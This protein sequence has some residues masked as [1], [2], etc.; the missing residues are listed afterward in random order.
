MEV[1]KNVKQVFEAWSEGKWKT[2]PRGGGGYVSI[3]TDGNT[4]F[5]YDTPIVMRGKDG[6]VLVNVTRYSN[7]TSLQQYNIKF[8]LSQAGIEFETIDNMP[9]RDYAWDRMKERLSS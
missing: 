2:A 1:R 8:A 4:I 9:Y 5:S 7:T 3:R 6:R